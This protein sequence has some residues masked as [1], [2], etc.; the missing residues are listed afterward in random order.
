MQSWKL[1]ITETLK[2]VT[3][4]VLG[5]KDWEPTLPTPGGE[6]QAMGHGS[7][8]TAA[9]PP[10]VRRVEGC[11]VAYNCFKLHVLAHLSSPAPACL[12]YRHV[13]LGSDAASR[14]VNVPGKDL[15][16][17]TSCGYTLTAP[18]IELF[19][20]SAGLLWHR[21]I[22]HDHHLQGSRVV[23]RRDLLQC[24]KRRLLRCNDTPGASRRSDCRSRS[25]R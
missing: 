25:E 8:M 23:L 13:P 16:G 10:K 6:G 5:P 24:L 4:D 9:M 1:V 19:G 15:S 17:D 11:R 18:D 7:S 3:R 20:E 22:I 2:S 12:I 21:T 14:E